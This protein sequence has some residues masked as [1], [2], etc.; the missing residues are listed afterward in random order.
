MAK[1]PTIAFASP[2]VLASASPRRAE[3]LRGLGIDFVV[4]PSPFPEPNARPTHVAIREWAEAMAYFKARA[5]AERVNG[6]W[7]LGADTVVACAG[8]MLG[9][10]RD[11]DDARRMLEMQAGVASDVVSGVALLRRGEVR[12]AENASVTSN[13]R[14]PALDTFISSERTR[15]Y[16]RDDKRLRDAYLASGDWRGKAGAYGIQDVGDALVERIEGGFDNVVGLP[17]SCVARMLRAATARDG[18]RAGAG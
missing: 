16:M 8:R 3:L 5:V 18:E 7:V 14:E 15:V 6:R 2:I 9:K 12:R 1:T 4:E 17:T 10:P 13:D 11:L